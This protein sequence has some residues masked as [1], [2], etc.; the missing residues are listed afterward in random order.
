MQHLQRNSAIHLK[1]PH[2]CSPTDNS[3]KSTMRFLKYVNPSLSFFSSSGLFLSHFPLILMIYLSNF[4]HSSSESVYFCE[5][6][7]SENLKHLLIPSA[8]LL[9]YSQQLSQ[10]LRIYFKNPR[11]LS[12]HLQQN[13]V[14]HYFPA[15]FQLNHFDDY[16]NN[17]SPWVFRTH[18]ANRCQVAWRKK[19]YENRT[20]WWLRYILKYL[21]SMSSFSSSK[22]ERSTQF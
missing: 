11:L 13:W 21:Y 4:N 2:G 8:P 9:Q 20:S 12:R 7:P 5:L 3:S 19:N 6:N 14:I 15:C 17:H 10:L 1:I 18:Q 22:R 16:P